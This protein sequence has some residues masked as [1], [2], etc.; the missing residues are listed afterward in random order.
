MKAEVLTNTLAYFADKIGDSVTYIPTH[1]EGDASHED[2]QRGFITSVNH[3]YVFV[4]F[5]GCTSQACDPADL[6]LG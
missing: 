2:C 3:K 4:R 6:K 5:N 1:A